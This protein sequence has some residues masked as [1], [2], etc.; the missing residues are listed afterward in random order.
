MAKRKK[1]RRYGSPPEVHEG[2]FR[3]DSKRFVQA[4]K[5]TRALINRKK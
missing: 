5:R 2:R 1:Q 4:V 3:G